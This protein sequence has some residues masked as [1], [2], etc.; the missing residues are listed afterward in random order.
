MSVPQYDDLFNPTLG[1]LRSLGGEAHI[2]NIE[3]EVAR[4]LNLTDEEI[5]EIHRG[6]T[7]KLVYRLAWSRNYLKRFGLLEK[8]ERGVWGLTEKGRNTTT[9][10]EDEVKSF[11]KSNRD[12]SQ[13]EEDDNAIEADL[14]D[15][16]DREEGNS[17]VEKEVSES[18]VI[19]NPFDPKEIDI[20]TKQMM[21]KALFERIHHEEVDML[22]DFQR[23]GDLWDLT[24]QSRLIESI[25][26]RFP[27]PAFYFDGTDDNKW[28]I[29]DGLQR[30]S[31]F[32]NF[33]IDKKIKGQPFALKNLEFL[34]D[35][36]G[37]TYDALPRDMKRRIDETEITVYII[38]PGTPSKVKYNLFKRINTSGLVLE[39]QEIRHALNQG[40][41]A[42][43]VRE[44]SLLP[45]FK[46]ATSYSIKTNRMLDR[47][48]VTRFVSFYVLGYK[49]YEPDL[50]TFLNKGMAEINKLSDDEQK[51]VKS[52]FVKSMKLAYD[53]F[54]DYAFRKRYKINDTR[55]PINKA[56]FETWSVNLARIEN[57]KVE[58]LVNKKE[59]LIAGFID[60]L[61]NNTDFEKAITSTTGD[62]GRVNRRFT[63][64]E[65]L[66]KNIL[67]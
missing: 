32:K 44:L 9:V 31:A 8:I 23:E 63:E 16:I 10:D 24:K 42:N 43:F 6:T 20:K 14:D 18:Y 13:D 55:K 60:L 64:I 56:L 41:P 51:K 38:S 62:K 37:S 39:P 52:N 48:F 7:T 11:V 40:V 5:N 17:Q 21:L 46:K 1:A 36:E 59:K 53:L 45:E 4:I 57:D 2:R 54:G 34:K 30:I 50:D 65:K 26:I 28:L 15:Y 58:E 33:I 19:T 12:N 61:S 3:Q 49:N 25:L 35:L 22:T 67:S 47:D 29:V 27:L 66:I